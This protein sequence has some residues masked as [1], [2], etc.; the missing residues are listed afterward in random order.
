LGWRNVR[1]HRWPV[2]CIVR[3]QT[4]GE[5]AGFLKLVTVGGERLLAATI[6]SAGATELANRLS[7]AMEAGMSLSR[8]TRTIHV[9]PTRG[10]GVF[11]LASAVRLEAAAASPAARLIGRLTFGR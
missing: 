10:F 8:L 3:A 7:L 2:E 1:V 11:Q 9:Y 6:A 5:T 4:E